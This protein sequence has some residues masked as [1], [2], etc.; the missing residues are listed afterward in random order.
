MAVPQEVKLARHATFLADDGSDPG[1][2][3]FTPVTGYAECN[4][5]PTTSGTP[6][7]NTLVPFDTFYDVDAV[8]GSLPAGLAVTYSAGTF[9][10]TEDGVWLLEVGVVLTAAPG[11]TGTVILQQTGIGFAPTVNVA[12][13]GNPDQWIGAMTLAKRSGDSFSLIE[14]SA[15]SSVDLI[16]GY[17]Q[18]K[19]VR[20]A[21]AVS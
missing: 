9:T 8:A 17:A 7:T 5:T 1:A 18:L 4:T 12:A 14:S 11:S 16:N 13:S 10:F 19:I 21:A 2:T 6:S 20:I 3:G 15:G